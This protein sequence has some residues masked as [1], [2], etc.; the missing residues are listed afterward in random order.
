MV[1]DFNEILVHH[2][3]R[4]AKHKTERQMARFKE[5]LEEGGLFDLCWKGDKYT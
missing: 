4:G 2:E 1:G 5:A 3:K